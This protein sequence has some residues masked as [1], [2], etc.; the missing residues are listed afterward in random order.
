MRVT[1]RNGGNSMRILAPEPV[2][3]HVIQRAADAL[4]LVRHQSLRQ[5]ATLSHSILQSGVQI[6]QAFR[7]RFPPLAGLRAV[8]GTISL[9]LLVTSSY[10]PLCQ[11]PEQLPSQRLSARFEQQKSPGDPDH[12]ASL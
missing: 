11:P 12:S 4:P 3:I 1:F 6:L 8:A 9:P 2:G 7:M 5:E 10:C